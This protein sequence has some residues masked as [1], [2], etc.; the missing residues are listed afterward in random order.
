MQISNAKAKISSA[1]IRY[2]ELRFRFVVSK[3]RYFKFADANFQR[4]SL[5]F[6]EEPDEIARESWLIIRRKFARTKNEFR[7][8]TFASFLHNTV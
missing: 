3:I 5:D 7:R 2:F 8:I 6:R 4:S 1:K